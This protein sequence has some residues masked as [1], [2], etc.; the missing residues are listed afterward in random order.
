MTTEVLA[1]PQPEERQGPTTAEWLHPEDRLLLGEAGLRMSEADYAL[2][3]AGLGM[4]MP[5][6]NED[7]DGDH[8]SPASIFWSWTTFSTV[9]AHPSLLLASDDPATS[10]VHLALDQIAFDEIALADSGLDEEMLRTVRRDWRTYAG[11]FA[12]LMVH[13]LDWDAL[14]DVRPLIRILQHPAVGAAAVI[15]DEHAPG[16]D[17]KWQWPLRI[18]T[19]VD[20]AAALPLDRL[21][22]MWPAHSLSEVQTLGRDHARSELLVVRGGLRE[23]LAK[24]LSLPYRVRT[25]HLLLLAPAD[26]RLQQDHALLKALMAET[27]AG[28]IS[29]V[30]LAPEHL[31][32]ALNA[33]IEHVSHNALYPAAVAAAFAHTGTQAQA[34]HIMDRRLGAAAKLDSLTFKLAND[35]LRLPESESL[36]LADTSASMSEIGIA[37]TSSAHEVGTALESRRMRFDNESG[38][39]TMV[40]AIAAASREAWRENAEREAPRFLQGDLRELGA[41]ADAPEPR[42]LVV[43]RDYRLDVLIAAE[44]LGGIVADQAFDDS[45]LDWRTATVHRL[46]VM[47]TEIGQWPEPVLGHL[48][49]PRSGASSRCELLFRPTRPGP[50]AGRVTLYHRGRVLQ[51][52][53][54]ECTVLTGDGNAAVD[55]VPLR[56]RVEA[57]VRSRM[58]TLDERRRFDACV[59][60]NHSVGGIATAAV[61]GEQGANINNLDTIR[62]YIVGI[63]A[64]IT[65][66]AMDSARHAKGLSTAAN[67]ELLCELANAGN[68]IH[69]GLVVDQIQHSSA[70]EALRKAEYLQIVSMRPDDPVPLEFVYDYPPPKDGA[71]VCRNAKKALQEGKC[72]GTCRPDPDTGEADHVCPMGFWGL[73]RVIERH[74]FDPELGHDARIKSEPVQGGGRDTLSLRGDLL[75]ATSDQ[76]PSKQRS[77]LRTQTSGFW[78]KHGNTIPVESWEEWRAAVAEK[79][80]VLLLALP[81]AGGTGT[82]ISLEISGKTQRSNGINQ[83]F[84]RAENATR[85]L[86]VLFGCDTAHTATVEAVTAYT[87]H[88]A[89]FRQADSALVLGTVA[90]VLGEDAAKV[91]TALVKRLVEQAAKGQA[92]G[93]GISFGEVLRDTKRQ[94]LI[95]SQMLAMCLV[96]YGDADWRLT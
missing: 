87:R 62:P 90:T 51:T 70:A 89:V 63:N 23:A 77:A 78:K 73:S 4:R 79:K 66:V 21:H 55:E 24:V 2:A 56:F 37:E 41:V 22:G 33:L 91:A 42:H 3:V 94:A 50:F 52:A 53:L 15:L 58:A 59:V 61:A 82:G 35:L 83:Q 92:D 76:V 32:T 72:P 57:C 64:A 68:W 45:Q 13:L 39:A 31:D 20:D 25:S 44:T 8:E 49:L 69:R 40:K 34:L 9:L 18:S 36:L 30:P 12:P 26:G 71:K 75:I 67:A 17:A 86:V 81:H 28:A 48:D 93:G 6:S 10:Y 54:L 43:G 5:A 27:Q 88:V 60:L 38:G 95:D 84:V 1:P 47:F 11:E 96:A 65:A 14:D 19:F 85:P 7:Q 46:Q 74:Q 16:F 29:L 80:P